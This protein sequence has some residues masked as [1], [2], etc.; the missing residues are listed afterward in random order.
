LSKR[1]GLLFGT[2]V[3]VFGLNA[4]L[5]AVPVG[6]F[7]QLQGLKPAKGSS[8]Q[9]KSP[10]VKVEVKEKDGKKGA[11][12]EVKVEGAQSKEK[13]GAKKPTQAK[14]VE[15]PRKERVRER[16]GRL[17]EA[18][19]KISEK[20]DYGAS[21]AASI[22]GKSSN[23]EVYAGI[24]WLKLLVSLGVLLC[25]FALER[26]FHW[27]IG[28]RLKRIRQ[29]HPGLVWR[30][31][32]LEALQK[33]L[34]LLLWVNGVYLALIPLYPHFEDP[35]GTNVV[36]TVA[37]GATD[38]ASVAAIIWFLYAL[39]VGIETRLQ[40]RAQA[41]GSRSD[42]VLA[43]LLGR[44]LR[45]FVLVLGAVV[46]LQSLTGLEIWPLLASLGLGGFAVAL[47]AKDSISNFFGTVTILMDKP[48][49]VGDRVVIGEHDGLVES[50][51]YRS[52]R[53]RT[54]E[55]GLVSIPNDKMIH[56]SVNNVGAR[57]HIRWHTNIGLRYDTPPDKVEKALEI[58]QQILRD[59][60]GMNEEHPPRVYFDGLKDG[61]LNL[62]IFAWYHPPEYWD[63]MA[64]VQAT[65]LAYLRRFHEE[66]IEI[67]IPSRMVYLGDGSGSGEGTISRC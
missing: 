30:G 7:A 62:T 59:H 31:F 40:A 5:I 47:A 14:I 58:L 63:Y 23:E 4:I 57:P 36:Y 64:W 51:G 25:F 33:P 16:F 21:K 37:S 41:S 26:L 54:F 32:I 60:E 45:T 22:F 8:E 49:S 28:A 65:C 17:Y 15:K 53:I 2:I 39:A 10:A 50:V 1:I 11:Q 27:L 38:F 52:T 56:A 29:R 9:A 61:T 6:A 42:K 34:S 18:G 55:G 13:T 67:A 44:T 35:D 19:R 46:I 48:F 12:V 66:G 24:K 20:I 3:I 43:S